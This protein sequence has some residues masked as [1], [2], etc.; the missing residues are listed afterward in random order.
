MPETSAPALQ[1]ASKRK[2]VGK[3]ERAA[4]RS[5]SSPASATYG[6]LAISL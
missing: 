3:E 5:N 2:E 1:K 4:A 6:F